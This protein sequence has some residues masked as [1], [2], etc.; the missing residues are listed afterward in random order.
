MSIENNKLT[1]AGF[2]FF[3]ICAALYMTVQF[4]SGINFVTL[5][6]AA[7]L[8]SP[9]LLAGFL[10]LKSHWLSFTLGCI[11]LVST[12]LISIP[13]FDKLSP[14]MLIVMLVFFFSLGLKIIRGDRSAVFDTREAKAMLFVGIVITGWFIYQRPSAFRLGSSSGGLLGALH[15]LLAVY[16]FW[17]MSYIIKGQFDAKSVFRTL[18]KIAAFVWVFVC[19]S[20]FLR[21]GFSMYLF[22]RASWM[23]F[24]LLLV[25]IFHGEQNGKIRG[26]G[27]RFF[28]IFTFLP[29]AVFSAYRSR[30]IFFLATVAV[31]S[32]FYGKMKRTFLV[33]LIVLT[34]GLVALISIKGEVPVRLI[35]PLSLIMPGLTFSGNEAIQMDIS[36]ET[37]WKS[38][39]RGKMYKMTWEKVIRSPL[40]G[41]GAKLDLQEMVSLYLLTNQEEGLNEMLVMSGSSHN[42]VLSIMVSYGVPAA[43][44]FI[45]AYTMLLGH[46][47]QGIRRMENSYLKMLCVAICG[48]MVGSTGQALMNGGPIDL[49]VLSVPLG[50]MNG[51]M[52]RAEWPREARQKNFIVR[53]SSSRFKA[54]AVRP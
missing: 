22:E 33:V 8:F 49:L 27:L 37:G 13:M 39:F 16:A 46:F 7:V 54:L 5:A 4:M 32:F 2:G 43:L 48:M 12:E 15:A 42:L 50:I 10:A 25:L 9:L 17:S 18:V 38:D 36:G 28:I 31:V 35:R 29:M 40:L 47:M 20:Q 52:R 24:P 6:K 41:Y 26:S 1:I 53:G 21:G 3:L 51:L 14:L 44:A 23:F 45:Y 34:I 30:P 11:P 19:G